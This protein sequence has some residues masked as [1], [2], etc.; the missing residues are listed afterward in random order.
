[1]IIRYLDLGHATAWSS[2]S[3]L[4]VVGCPRCVVFSISPL[5]HLL[6]WQ[7]GFERWA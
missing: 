7:S 4:A 5:G 2:Q 6:V 1:M 3:F